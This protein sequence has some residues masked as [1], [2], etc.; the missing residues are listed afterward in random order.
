M[1]RSA[2]L[3]IEQQQRLNE[4]NTLLK[5]VTNDRLDRF[6]VLRFLR[7]WGHGAD[8]TEENYTRIKALLQKVLLENIMIVRNDVHYRRLLG[9]VNRILQISNDRGYKCCLVGC[10][11]KAPRHR[12]YLCHLR[13]VHPSL[14][15]FTCNY[16]KSC[17]VNTSDFNSLVAHIERVHSG[18]NC[19]TRSGEQ[20]SASAL[21]DIQRECKCIL[22]SCGQKRFTSIRELMSHIN[23]FHHRESR[24]CIFKECDKKFAG[25][26]VS[27]NHFRLK[28]I[29][30]CQVE[31]K[32]KHL[33]GPDLNEVDATSD[34][35][36]DQ[37]ICSDDYNNCDTEKHICDMEDI[38]VEGLS[39]TVME[40]S[41]DKEVNILKSYA[42][43]LNKLSH[44]NFVPLKTVEA[45]SSE[46]MEHY[47]KSLPVI[48][49][50]LKTSLQNKNL[51]ESEIDDI[52]L[53]VFG[54]DV[55]LAA[56]QEVDTIYKLKKFI[57]ENFNY[58]APVEIVLNKV[59]VL[60][61]MK[62]ECFHYIP[63]VEALKT[64]LEDETF[65]ITEE[66]K[67]PTDDEPEIIE[68]VK[69]GSAYRSSQF[70][71]LNPDAYTMMIYSDA[72]ELGELS[73]LTLHITLY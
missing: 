19:S 50:N 32:N 22:L 61:G 24:A 71:Q 57:R 52:V 65:I 36:D 51:S 59:E 44:V 49:L 11:F 46:F 37:D 10:C 41:D 1:E 56:Q 21:V 40:D 9:K 45:F 53:E 25:K 68:D 15:I 60:K 63:I 5:Q 55:F 70:F 62:K 67:T 47:N 31:L 73:F 16:K 7:I 2:V 17:Y 28:H 20:P 6:Q 12:D 39:N 54:H 33:V 23:T 42:N 38:S 66:T 35:F 18:N 8:C 27:R 64:L 13:D 69:D 14:T 26:A 4:A 48:K 34:L 43:S 72:V 30:L 58:V 29:L 3:E